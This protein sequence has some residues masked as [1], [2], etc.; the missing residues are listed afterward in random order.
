M[1]LLLERPTDTTAE[2]NHSCTSQ[3]PNPCPASGSVATPEVDVYE[4]PQM[5]K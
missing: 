3:C 5:T 1:P 4:S 2:W